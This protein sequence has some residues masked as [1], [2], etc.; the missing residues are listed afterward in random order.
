MSLKKII[1]FTLLILS[2]ACAPKTPDPNQVIQAA[3]QQTIAAIPTYTPYP[4]QRIP[5]TP[6]LTNLNGLFCEYQFCIGHPVDMAFFDASAQRN[7]AAPSTISQGWVASLNASLFIQLMWQDAP[8]VKDAQFMLDLIIDSK[9]D[10]RSGS[11]DPFQVGDITVLYVPIT[12]T[13]TSV[14][15]NGGAAVWTCGGRAFA[16]KVY[17]PQPD[18]AKGLAMD[19]LKKFRCN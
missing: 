11:L 19:A 8:G 13:A 1:V 15:P 7:P 3:V 18:T 16:W 12:T 9:V 4:T 2:A 5:A 14:L 6:T 10:T 17:S